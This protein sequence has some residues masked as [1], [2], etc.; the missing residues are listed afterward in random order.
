[1]IVLTK[2][3]NKVIEVPEFVKDEFKDTLISNQYYYNDCLKQVFTKDTYNVAGCLDTL[4]TLHEVIFNSNIDILFA[5]LY[6]VENTNRSKEDLLDE[7]RKR[8]T[9]PSKKTYKQY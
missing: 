9:A 2:E 1:M 5:M 3:I 7:I 4:D 8:L 6:G